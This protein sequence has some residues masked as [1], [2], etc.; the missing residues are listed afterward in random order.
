MFY[1]PDKGGV[2]SH[3]GSFIAWYYESDESKLIRHF[4]FR[5]SEMTKKTPKRIFLVNLVPEA[6]KSILDTLL[7]GF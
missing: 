6:Q 7:L 2:H 3:Q 1:E 5:E 4:M